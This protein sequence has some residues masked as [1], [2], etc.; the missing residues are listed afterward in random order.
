MLTYSFKLLIPKIFSMSAIREI[1]R[2]GPLPVNF[3]FTVLLKNQVNWILS[4]VFNWQYLYA[5]W[6]FSWDILSLIKSLP[7]NGNYVRS[8][9]LVFKFFQ[10]KRTLSLLTKFESDIQLEA[11]AILDFSQGV[12]L[13][14][15]LYFKDSI[16]WPFLVLG[17]FLLISSTISVFSC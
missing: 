10:L 14:F 1:S 11:K 2:R 13:T 12:L 15:S 17:I 16:E 8:E 7:G 5:N 6:W 3:K 9:D 4:A